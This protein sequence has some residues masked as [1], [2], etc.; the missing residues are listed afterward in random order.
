MAWTALAGVGLNGAG[1]TIAIVDA[2]DDPTIANDLHV[3]DRT[4]GLPDPKFIKATP[5]GKPQFDAGWSSE[6]ALDVEWAHAIAPGA[7]ILLVEAR[8]TSTSDL[9]AA[10]DYA[11]RAGAKEVSMSF[12]ASAYA[13][14]SA[15]DLHFDHP[16]VTFIAA[17]GDNGAEVEYPAD[18][19]F[20][21]AVGGTSLTIDT[22]GDRLAETAWSDGGGGTSPLEARPK[23]QNGFL[24]TS[25]RGVP[26][27]SWNAN[28]STGVSVYNSSSGGGWY[29]VGGT[30]AGAPAWAGLI[31]LANQGRAIWGKPSLGTGLP[32]GTNQALY[33]LAGGT[34]YTNARGDFSD[35][36]SGSNGNPAARG[37]DLATGLGSPVANRLVADLIF[38]F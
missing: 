12:G 9:F 14:M 17:A 23:Y 1:Q 19:P 20:V 27:V 29:Q 4:Y 26:D 21:T 32:Y 28:P 33:A 11:V 37:Y 34:S 2:Y 38:N 13:G 35:I 25:A 22:L 10:V 6:I 31:A 36:T 24:T 15:S 30:S 5:E 18:S 8:S 7:T 3:F 16:G